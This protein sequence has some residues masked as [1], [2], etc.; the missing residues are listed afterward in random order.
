M[1]DLHC[2][3]HGRRSAPRLGGH[4]SGLCVDWHHATKHYEE[5]KQIV[6]KTRADAAIRRY[7]R[8]QD[9]AESSL[10]PYVCL[11]MLARHAEAA[12]I[13]RRSCGPLCP[14]MPR[15]LLAKLKAAAA[16]QQMSLG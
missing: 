6:G 15:D 7:L 9:A 14:W 5:F 1:R 12:T 11:L 2:V 3:D 10:T 16:L 8:T 4:G 13:R